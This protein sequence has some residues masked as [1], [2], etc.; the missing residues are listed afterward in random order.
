MLD[1]YV[2]SDVAYSLEVSSP[3]PDRPLGK[4][5]DFDRFKGNR[6][7]VRTHETFEGKNK[8]RGVLLGSAADRV[9]LKVGDK[10]VSIPLDLV[11][12]ARLVNYHGE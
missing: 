6:A 5:D 4:K 11:K 10:T 2:D 12:R 9:N 1:V 3:G 7:E 8:F